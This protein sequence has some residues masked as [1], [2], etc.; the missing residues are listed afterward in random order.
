MIPINIGFNMKRRSVGGTKFE[1]MR[2]ASCTYEPAYFWLKKCTIISIY[3]IKLP[4]KFAVL[5]I[6]IFLHG[7]ILHHLVLLQIWSIISLIDRIW[8]PIL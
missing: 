3:G 4:N 5:L 6:S 8:A 7:N 1:K 2:V